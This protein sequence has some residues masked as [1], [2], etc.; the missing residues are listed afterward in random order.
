MR[1]LF[2]FKKKSETRL[3]CFQLDH[4]CERIQTQAKSPKQEKGFEH[5]KR[6]IGTSYVLP[7]PKNKLKLLNRAHLVVGEG[8]G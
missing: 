6:C 2:Q 7:P 8:R 4:S 1:K 5:E 3:G